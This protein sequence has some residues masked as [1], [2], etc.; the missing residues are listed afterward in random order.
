MWRMSRRLRGK[1]KIKTEI[2][3]DEIFAD[4]QNIQE[5]NR[6]QFEGRIEQPISRRAFLFFG[7][8]LVF[9]FVG[10]FARAGD[11]QLVHGVAYAKQA[12]NNQLTQHI[13]FADR[14][15]L[16]DR[17]DVLL[18]YN[19]RTSL[20]NDF[21]SRVY[22]DFHGL[23]HVIGYAQSP[24]KDSS[25]VYFRTTFTGIDGVE[26]AFDT[27][28]GGQ[29]GTKLSETDA[30]GKVVSESVVQRQEAGQKIMLS[31]DAAVTQGLYEAIAARAD[32]S[33]FQG[34]AGV[35]I[36]IKTGEL[37]VLTSYPEYSQNALYSGDRAEFAA[38]N[39]DP[40]QP[41]LDR[42]TNGLYAP[43]SIVKPIVAVAALTENIIDPSKQILSTGSI[44][45]PN[46]YDPAHPSVFRDWRAH[47]WVD[48]RRALAVSSDVY[49]YEVGG[50]FPGQVGLGITKLE[51]YFK[52][53]GLGQDTG[54]IG[55]SEQKGNI[56]TPAWKAVNFPDDPAWRL[57]NTYHT[58]IGQYGMQITPLQAARATAAIASGGVLLT[59]TLLVYP[60]RSGGA[61][62]TPKGTVLPISQSALQIA[63]EGMRLSVTEGIAQSVK[64]G[65]VQVAAKTGTAQIGAH[66]EY[67][68][69]WM[70]GFWPYENPR[71]AY[72]VVLE[73]G[74][75][76]TLM[77]APAVMGSF[78]LWMHQNAPQYL[79]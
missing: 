30:R 46:P 36:D 20:T 22:A 35:V 77:G 15:I 50:G 34:G 58:A 8:I 76:G 71:Y 40:R 73:R 68:N 49:F 10:F 70:I 9:L 11:L 66:N 53:F 2:H 12:K 38:F 63:R 13:I 25:D 60:D 45:V 52:M 27:E 79:Q 16:V 24:A 69:S 54:L 7:G 5:F 57:G 47:G 18:A 4:S 62:S 21:A 42:A 64:F 56:P 75:A 1:G 31:I 17:T 39:N 41:F 29:N 6:D 51:K 55:F 74:P 3:P 59:P 37:L 43:G 44:S 65:F 32:S 19:S 33:K 78:F 23:S 14:G 72:A 26:R 28:L 61:S 48:M 67:M